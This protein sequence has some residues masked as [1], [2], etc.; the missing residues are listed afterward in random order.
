MCCVWFDQVC[1]SNN[2][3]VCF[4]AYSPQQTTSNVRPLLFQ[5]I[6]FRVEFGQASRRFGMRNLQPQVLYDV[7]V[8]NTDPRQKMEVVLWSTTPLSFSNQLQSVYLGLTLVSLFLYVVLTGV[9]LVLRGQRFVRCEGE[10]V[11]SGSYFITCFKIHPRVGKLKLKEFP[12][13]DLLQV[14]TSKT[15]LPQRTTGR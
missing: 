5:I 9:C 3:E 2:V 11:V 1:I 8:D 14:R 6:S 4:W 13:N 10:V 7:V 12:K 15:S